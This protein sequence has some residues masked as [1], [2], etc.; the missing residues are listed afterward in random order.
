M[1]DRLESA[2]LS[3]AVHAEILTACQILLGLRYS[4]ALIQ[5]L[6]RGLRTMRE[7]STYMAILEEGI[8]KGTEKG[9]VEGIEKGEI[10]GFREAIEEIGTSHFG[11]PSV[12][13][14]ASLVEI[15]DRNRLR[16]MMRQLRTVA[17]W[18]DLLEVR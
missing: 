8:E 13:M 14:L 3:V 11:A 1:E 7:S 16:R 6:Y 17:T 10:L 2:S 15:T 4:K 9:R 18:D 12:S 5:A